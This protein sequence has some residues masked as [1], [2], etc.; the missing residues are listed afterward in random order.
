M[1]KF[2][3]TPEEVELLKIEGYTDAGFVYFPNG[4]G[5]LYMM[6]KPDW[7]EDLSKA[8]TPKNTD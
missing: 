7:M 4:T 2:V 6:E 8:E 3:R 1:I 5:V